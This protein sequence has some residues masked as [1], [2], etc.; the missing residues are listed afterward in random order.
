MYLFIYIYPK[1]NLPDLTVP[2]EDAEDDVS[3]V[4]V[5]SCIEDEAYDNDFKKS[6]LS[7][8]NI[9]EEE[10]EEAPVSRPRKQRQKRKQVGSVLGHLPQPFVTA[11]YTATLQNVAAALPVFMACVSIY[12]CRN[13][14][15][16]NELTILD[17]TDL[18][19]PR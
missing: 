8:R 1:S 14:A 15:P 17:S 12:I 9:Q 11:P 18:T 13:L 19:H 10:E 3:V 16:Q 4:S 6:I 2:V 7:L 5:V